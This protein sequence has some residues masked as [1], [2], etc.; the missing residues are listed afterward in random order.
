MSA[1]SA[2]VNNE[3]LTTTIKMTVVVHDIAQL[4]QVIANIRKVESVM[5][6]ERTNL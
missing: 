6:V 4:N 3:S 5:S 1:V 2:V